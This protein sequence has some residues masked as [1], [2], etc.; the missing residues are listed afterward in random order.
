MLGRVGGSV[1]VEG[2][3]LVEGKVGVTG[4][5]RRLI[6]SMVVGVGWVLVGVG[7]C[8]GIVGLVGWLIGCV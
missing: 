3:V 4:S 7:G 5:H 2:R 1:G 6:E 8:V